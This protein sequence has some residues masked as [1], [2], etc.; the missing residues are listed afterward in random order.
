MSS[1]SEQTGSCKA[2]TVYENKNGTGE[3]QKKKGKKVL[4][5]FLA[6]LGCHTTSRM[7]RMATKH[8]NGGL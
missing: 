2:G 3:Y 8:V 5:G 6:H 7:R 1:E 4:M